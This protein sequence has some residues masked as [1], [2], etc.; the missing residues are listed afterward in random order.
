MCTTLPLSGRIEFLTMIRQ[1]YQRHIPLCNKGGCRGGKMTS[2]ECRM[3]RL[4]ASMS[5]RL[6][7]IVVFLLALCPFCGFEEVQAQQLN[8]NAF[9]QRW[10]T[11]HDGMVSIAE[12]RKAAAAQFEKMSAARN[13]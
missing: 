12:V 11:D 6:L 1:I 2:G 3:G 5:T 13:C 7:R 10:D 8:M 4:D 9:L